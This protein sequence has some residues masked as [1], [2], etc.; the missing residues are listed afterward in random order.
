MSESKINRRSLFGLFA[1]LPLVAASLPAK[2]S[3]KPRY[4]DQERAEALAFFNGDQWPADI[5]AKRLI[6]K[7]PCIVQNLLPD[8]LCREH[9]EFTPG[10]ISTD[11]YIGDKLADAI[12][13]IV[14]RDRDVNRLHNLCVSNKAEEEALNRQFA[15]VRV[16]N[17]DLVFHKQA[18]A[19]V[20]P[21]I[22]KGFDP[23]L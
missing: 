23:A 19:L 1:G 6:N 2:P 11:R 21:E 14:R 15:Q 20:W 3:Y 12:V 4:S 10:R 13:D 18:F 16:G 17:Q 9:P 7:R 5:R 8:R 22:G